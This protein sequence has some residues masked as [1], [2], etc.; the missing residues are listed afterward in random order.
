MKRNYFIIFLIA[1]LL[2]S[3]CTKFLDEK[4]NARLI[5]P[6][7][8]DH[9]Q[10]LLDRESS[11]NATNSTGEASAD[12]YYATSSDFFSTNEVSKN[13]YIWGPELVFNNLIN[14]WANPY[15]IINFTNTALEFLTGS[16][17]RTQ[18]NEIAWDYI[19]GQS[20]VLRAKSFLILLEQ[21]ALAY[22]P[23][24]AGTDPGIVLRLNS[25]IN[26]PT[27]RSSVQDC[28]EKILADLY[29]SIKYLPVVPQHVLRISKPAAYA[30]LSKTYLFSGNFEK[31]GLYAD[32]CLQLHHS[33]LDYNS[34]TPTLAFPFPP[35]NPEVI[36]HSDAGTVS[37]MA[38][39]R[40]K[41][42]SNLYNS[43]HVNDLRKV[44]F[45]RNNGNG[46]YAFKGSYFGSSALFTGIATDEIYLIR[47]ECY[48]ENG[49]INEAMDDLNTL[50][51]TRWK[52]GTFVPFTASTREEAIQ[53]VR[54][55]RRKETLFRDLRWNDI[56]R[57]NKLGANI[58]IRRII[59]NEEFLLP[60]NDNRFALPIPA[61]VVEISGIQQNPR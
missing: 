9:L 46:T 11:I 57:W 60:P 38:Q 23:A 19:K 14:A 42:D 48:A 7:T 17:T 44:L 53:L 61:S 52:T 4:P 39:S 55:E 12:N 10:R 58:S 36:F 15:T 59:D 16:I 31:A 20:L 49:Q 56:K 30:F 6:A 54:Q 25:D 28:Y 18:Q 8:P 21:F 13:H 35:F 29:E 5:I 51:V 47:A 43:Y 50:L 2:I 41:I 37:I 34:L 24:T 3:G 40:G 45:F 33:L 27:V 1:V 22:D 26:T 32:S